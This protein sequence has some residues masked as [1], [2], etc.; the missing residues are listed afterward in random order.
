MKISNLLE[1]RKRADVIIQNCVM[2]SSTVVN[3]TALEFTF[4][5]THFC[6]FLT[7]PPILVTLI[8]F[9]RSGCFC[10][11]SE[12]YRCNLFPLVN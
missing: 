8:L 1:R 10:G 4:E 3:P 7:K 5:E 2:Y 12:Y 9:I 11:Y 6:F